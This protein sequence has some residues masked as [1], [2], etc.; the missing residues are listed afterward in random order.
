MR[1]KICKHLDISDEQILGMR[2]E[3]DAVIVVIN[4]G[5]QGGK[6]F[7]INKADLADPKP[8]PAPKPAPKKRTA[9]KKKATK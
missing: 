4:Y 7:S 1:A 9:A 5:I 3:G 6:K 2:D 8:E